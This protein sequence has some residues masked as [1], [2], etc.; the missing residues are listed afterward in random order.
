M[1]NE[2][3]NKNLIA[4]TESLCEKYD[5]KPAHSKGQNFLVCEEIYDKI[6]S[7]AQIKSDDEILEVGPGLGFLTFK[8]AQIAKK[9]IAVELDDQLSLLLHAQIR[10]QGI[11][12][13]E[14]VNQD[15]FN[16]LQQGLDIPD[17]IVA[18]LPYN[19]TS[20]FL[21]QVFSLK[22]KPR[23]IVL[24]LQKEVVERICAKPPEMNLLALSVQVY[25]EARQLFTVPKECFWPEPQVESAVIE[26]NL[27]EQPFFQDSAQEKQFFRL[28]RIGFA[29]KRKMLKN[30]LAN[31][32][33]CTAKEAED[34]IE[35]SGLK[36][37]VRAQDLDLKNWRILADL[38]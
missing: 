33:H 9:I 35:K 20:F 38:V 10:E 24:L 7:V 34:I 23:K 31:G 25:A 30:N 29:Q 14:V 6:I 17:K 36:L 27:R 32:L 1:S 26:I 5:I 19:I 37:N 4:Q 3:Y 18:N 2:L 16:F 15:I 22:N 11:T 21:R 28:A 13:I 8:L 12:N